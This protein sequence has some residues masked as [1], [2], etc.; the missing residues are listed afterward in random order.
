MGIGPNGDGVVLGSKW[1]MLLRASRPLSILL[2]APPG[3]G[4]TTGIV[5]PSLLVMQNSVIVHD[6]KGELYELTAD[7]RRRFSNVFLF[8]PA[9]AESAR[10]NLLSAQVLPVE[11]EKR[12]PYIANIAF[13]F[14]PSAKGS[15]EEFFL[16]EA[17]KAFCFFAEYLI[18]RHGETSMPEIR[19]TLLSFEDVPKAISN[20]IEFGTPD[21]PSNA[22]INYLAELKQLAQDVSI[23]K[24]SLQETPQHIVELGRA[25]LQ[26]AASD[27]QWAAVASTLSQAFDVFSSSA[28]AQATSSSS[29]FTGEILRQK[30]VTVYL[31][32]RDQ[33]RKRLA[34]LM[35]AT[36]DSLVTQL[37]STTPR[38]YSQ[39]VCFVMD[40]FVRLGRIE[41]LKDLPAIGRG[42]RVNA[43]FAAQ[44]YD[45]I[46]DVYD[47]ETVNI[48]NTNCAYK[49]ILQ[50]NNAETADKLSKLIGNQTVDKISHSAN[51]NAKNLFDRSTG[52]SVSHEGI[53]L[54][55]AQAILGLPTK[56]CLVLAQG[57]N[58]RP[59]RASVPFFFKHPRLARLVPTQKQ[60]S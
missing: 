8:D 28:V 1:G 5:V 27:R 59:I 23:P 56:Q 14:L 55:T 12:S 41:Y 36:I 60:E 58:N 42:Y 43:L 48:L 24:Q 40:E 39:S 45:Q 9:E 15:N 57:S 20:I 19:R 13:N 18:W 37:I 33:D 26:S 46:A 10:Y 25:V 2:L 50:Q 51:R 38:S 32:V 16:R 6:P 7:H 49:I 30:P 54:V 47:R 35:A 44:D 21:T 34:P 11:Q 22:P 29:D 53:P 31:K 4:K 17:R 3:T 52:R